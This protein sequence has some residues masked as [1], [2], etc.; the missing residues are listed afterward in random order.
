M[1][2]RNYGADGIQGL[3]SQAPGSVSLLLSDLPSGQ[4]VA[5]FDVPM[6]LDA[7]WAAAWAAV[8]PTGVVVLM[9]S[10]MRFASLVL[11]SCPGPRHRDGT[12]K[13]FRYDI[14][15]EKTRATG[16]YNAKRQPMRAHEHLLVFY[17]SQPT[18]NPQK[19]EGHEPMHY[20]ERNGDH[21][22]NYGAGDGITY[23]DE[24]ATDR[25]PRSVLK[26]APVPNTDSERHPQQKPVPLL[27]W[28]VR[29]YTDPG[30]L[31][32]D[33]C[34]GSFSTG[35][36]AMAE[37]RRFVGWELLERFRPEQIGLFSR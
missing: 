14:V 10:S 28:V 19:T 25:Y 1:N 5:D 27:R 26:F 12:P 31:V 15:W 29:T 22:E 11:G 30:E 37:G 18:Y 6:D 35:D 32:A 8:K 16:H 24:G 36:A 23:A 17:R 3:S 7:L 2:E 13:W 33:V 34:A 4:T 9:A 21:G 20:A